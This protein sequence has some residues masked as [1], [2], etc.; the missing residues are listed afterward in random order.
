MANKPAL[1]HDVVERLRLLARLEGELLF[2][3][4]KKQPGS[5]VHFSERISNAIAKVTDAV[6]ERLAGVMPT[7]S[8][9]KE[10]LP[11]IRE[12]LPKKLAEL[13]GDRIAKRY[14]VQYQRN[15]IASGIAAR[16]V[17][18]EGISLIE[19]QPLEKLADRAI[20]YYLE[21]KKVQGVLAKLENQHFGDNAKIK[22][23]VLE[24]L[25]KGGARTMVEGF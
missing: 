17:Y 6:T 12:N 18:Q 9:F 3:E 22:P 16:L 8:L 24:M 7:D 11:V 13:G 20:L 10:L 25:R 15:A 5:L 14:P 4:F 23:L 19:S 2:K 21:D 1:V